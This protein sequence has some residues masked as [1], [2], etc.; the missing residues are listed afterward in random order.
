M[1]GEAPLVLGFSSSVSGS[2]V[3]SPFSGGSSYV[4]WSDALDYWV[5]LCLCLLFG[6]K[7]WFWGS[8]AKGFGR[9]RALEGVC[10]FQIPILFLLFVQHC[11]FCLFCHYIILDL[12]MIIYSCS[13]SSHSAFFVAKNTK[14]STLLLETTSQYIPSLLTWHTY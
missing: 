1:R 13:N 2:T 7:D 3:G 6:S 12:R 14:Q 11:M 10:L 4:C 8:F 9:W 5:V